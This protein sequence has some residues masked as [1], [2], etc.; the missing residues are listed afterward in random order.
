M[1]QVEE[2]SAS[3]ACL[4]RLMSALYAIPGVARVRHEIGCFVW[5][6]S[7]PFLPLSLRHSH[8]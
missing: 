6:H 7:L 1:E 2:L 4:L 8:F 5:A 3:L